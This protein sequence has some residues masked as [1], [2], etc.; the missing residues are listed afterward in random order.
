MIPIP[1]GLA[2]ELRIRSDDPAGAVD[3]ASGTISYVAGDT[4]STHGYTVTDADGQSSSA[5]VTILVVENAAP[6]LAPLAIETPYETPITIELGGQANDPDGDDLFFVCCDN[7]RNGTATRNSN[8]PNAYALTFTPDSA[9]SGQAGFSYT[10]DDQNG[11]QVSGSVT[12]TVAP[13][14][15]VAPTA[16]GAQVVVEAGTTATVALAPLA[17]DADIPT[18]DVLT[19]SVGEVAGDGISL[20]GST[21]SVVA[22][23]ADAGDERSIDYIVTDREGETATATVS[24]T[25]T[26]S[27][28]PP[29]IAVADSAETTQGVLVAVDVLANDVD[30]IGDG[31]TLLSAGSTSSIGTV[32]F[33]ADGTISYTP[34]ADFFGT[35]NITYS[36]EDARA[37]EAGRAS[38]SLNVEVVGRPDAPP[39]PEAVADN[40]TAT[41]TWGQPASNGGPITEFELESNQGDLV[42]LEPTSS[43]TLDDLVNGADY[44]FRVRAQNEA[45]W[46]EWSPSSAV[47]TPDIEPGRPGAPT[48]GFAD[49]ALDVTWSEPASEGSAI[50]GYV[51]EIG[52]GQSSTIELPAST[53]YTWPNLTNGTNYQFRV[54]AQNRSGP[55][56]VSAWSI[57]EHPLREPDQAA[58]IDA[59]QGDGFLDLDWSAPGDNGDPI[60]EY[61]VEM[62]SAPGQPAT[63]T[64]PGFRWADLPNGV[65]QR[66]RTRARNRDADWSTWSGWSNSEKPCGV[67]DRPVAPVAVRGDTEISGSP[68][69]HRPTTVAHSPATR[70]PPTPGSPAPPVRATP[71]RP[72]P[73]SRTARATRSRSQRPTCEATAQPVRHRTR[74]SPPD[75]RSRRPT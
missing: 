25:V 43:H 71:A 50:T 47:V 72:S 15:N 66:F 33:T 27:S 20:S 31:L 7:V 51:L 35:A 3:A 60:I 24:I 1:D 65:F 67:P 46:G 64:S 41:I 62:E 63:T 21:V 34:S 57:T 49:G 52:G 48:V 61:Q 73:G 17:E 45:G 5:N 55:S 68:G 30:E 56:D 39:T 8:G 29:P 70:S 38:G 59:E 28:A 2:S 23:I 16:E 14:E 12:V 26:E 54:I 10:V 13:R 22:D 36:I 37:T 19:F 4:N 75:H 53:S 58:A 69:R 11:H 18:G 40:A 32:D 74:S 6:T 42:Q 44:T 9:F